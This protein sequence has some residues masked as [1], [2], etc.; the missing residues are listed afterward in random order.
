M[1]K[2]YALEVASTY[3][4]QGKLREA[5]DM[6]RDWLAVDPNNAEACN[7]LGNV[8][9]DA[10]RAEE[11]IEFY[12]R[13]ISINPGYLPAYNN[14]GTALRDRGRVEDAIAHYHTAL[15]ISQSVPEV[16]N[17]LGVALT[18]LGRIEKAL[19]AYR[20]AID[21]RPNYVDAHTN[22]G[23]ALYASG[24]THGAVEACGRAVEIDPAST[25]AHNNLA[26]ILLG[27][28][29]YARGWAEHEWRFKCNPM[30]V[31]RPFEQP[32]WKGE[33]LH[34]RTVFLHAEQGL[35]DTI[36]FS[37]FVPMVAQR[38][39]RVVLECQG[40]LV[41]LLADLPGLNQIIPRG[42]EAPTFDVHCPLMSLPLALGTTTESIPA[43]PYI[44]ARG[45]LR[46]AWSQR[47]GP[48]DRI[49]VG[50]AWAGRLTHSNDANRSMRFEQVATF[51]GT[52]W[53]EFHSLQRGPAS[54]QISGDA[55]ITDH[56]DHF[57]DF[58]ETAGLMA[59]LDLVICVDTAVAHL[60][61][62]MGKPTW[63][64]LPY[65][66]EWRWMIGREDSPWYP[67]MRLFRQR[68]WGDWQGVIERVVHALSHGL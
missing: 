36:Q 26:L 61:A 23:I 54:E 33:P 28:G 50:L 35:G 27:A 6:Y 18:E 13:A 55:R 44:G 15:A 68:R 46:A 39:G 57:T 37:R 48:V 8:L 11:S 66:S 12:Q 41:R 32:Q 63:V 31:A 34:G 58:A 65:A 4:R 64:L 42:A 25:K 17:N 10:G 56:S 51:L 49:R 43:G 22:F 19:E 16:Y 38:G 7:D 40:E 60:A 14:L 5:E 62:A 1:S 30:F 20:R 52:G 47:L 45:D 3:H 2:P 29:E 21:M 59:N 53:M 9:C 67:T 24:D